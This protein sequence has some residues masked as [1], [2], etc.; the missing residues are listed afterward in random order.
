MLELS[1]EEGQKSENLEQSLLSFYQSLNADLDTDLEKRQGIRRQTD[2]K[3][4]GIVIRRYSKDSP[5]SDLEFTPW[6]T[7]G[8]RITFRCQPDAKNNFFSEVALRFPK[9]ETGQESVVLK[10]KEEEGVSG[11]IPTKLKEQAFTD[12]LDVF[13]KD[14]WQAKQRTSKSRRLSKNRQ[15]TRLAAA[16][17]LGTAISSIVCGALPQDQ[18]TTLVPP[19]TIESSDIGIYGN[20]SQAWFEKTWQEIQDTPQLSF[21]EKLLRLAPNVVSVRQIS[22]F[23]IPTPVVM[24]KLDIENPTVQQF[25]QEAQEKIKNSFPNGYNPTNLEQVSALYDFFY[26]NTKDNFLEIAGLQSLS[27]EIDEGGVCIGQAYLLNT[28]LEKIV[29]EVNPRII[30]AFL[31]KDL[32]LQNPNTPLNI[33]IDLSKVFLAGGPGHTFVVFE[34]DGEIYAADSNFAPVPFKKLYELYYGFD[35]N[36]IVRWVPPGDSVPGS[37]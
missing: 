24:I 16:I 8:A 10:W 15:R 17:S 2:G 23:D 31:S 37:E 30:H 1:V 21:D 35:I 5:V 6:N 36:D 18:S 4:I 20:T 11:P 26:A 22:S 25:I 29:P 3:P 7:N 14:D 13:Q 32:P 19:P 33:D 9:S 28:L 12:G 34:I 27:E